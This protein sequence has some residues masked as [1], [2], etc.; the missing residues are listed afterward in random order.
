MSEHESRDG[1]SES[2]RKDV[3]AVCGKSTA[4]S[5]EWVPQP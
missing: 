2:E 1:L 5:D 4:P 3:C